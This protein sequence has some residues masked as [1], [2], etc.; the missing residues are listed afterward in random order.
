V[1]VL[2]AC[3]SI[4]GGVPVDPDERVMSGDRVKVN[5]ELTVPAGKASVSLQNGRIVSGGIDRFV[6]TCRFVM[7]EI[8]NTSQKIIP[9]E[10]QVTNVRYWEDFVAPDYRMHFSGGEFITYEITLRLHS[11]KLP[12]LHSLV[13]KHDDEQ[14]D[15]RHLRLSEMQEALGDFARIIKTKSIKEE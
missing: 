13:C 7:K 9:A 6:A 8:K 2:F 4:P 12:E 15:G 1:T 3:Q 5:R 14:N 10:F 11:E